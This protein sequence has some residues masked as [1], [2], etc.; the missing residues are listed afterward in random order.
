[1]TVHVL[2]GD[3]LA[4]EFRKTG[5]TGEIIVCREALIAGPIDAPGSDE[6]WA[7]RARFVFGEYGE[8]EISY[9]ERVAD[10]LEKL[11][12]LAANDEIDLWFEY[13]LFCSVNLWFCL[14]LIADNGCS[15]FRV[16]PSVLSS[17]DRWDG[18]G[19]MSSKEL[20]ECFAD[21]QELSASDVGLG[22]SLWDAYRNGNHDRLMT[23]AAGD[24]RAFPYLEEVCSAAAEQET[25]PRDILRSIKDSG[26]T[27]FGKI[28]AEFKKRAGVYGYG[29]LQ[30]ES[31]LQSL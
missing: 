30:V 21:R 8:D 17:S 22:R 15:V 14:S 1:M 20:D 3:T 19:K 9:Q 28:F 24:N 10:E 27:D 23:L 7:Q 25:L 16:S 6:F 11:T 31:L 18:F 5:I 2:A 13:E 4:A 12:E 26:E 29:D